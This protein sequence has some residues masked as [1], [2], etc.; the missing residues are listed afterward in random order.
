MSGKNKGLNRLLDR[1]LNRLLGLRLGGEGK[2]EL[3]QAGRNLR[4]AIS[5]RTKK[6]ANDV[7]FK[8]GFVKD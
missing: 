6:Q 7:I 4:G 1:R 5:R 3:K 8:Y 2:A